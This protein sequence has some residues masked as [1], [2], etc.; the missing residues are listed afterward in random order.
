MTATDELRRLLAERGVEYVDDEGYGE[1]YPPERRITWSC[2]IAGE[3]MTVTARDYCIGI[4]DDGSSVYY[5]DLDFHEVFTPEQAVE[6]TLGRG[7]C[8]KLPSENNLTCIVRHEPTGMT[9]EYGYWR[10]SN[11]GCNCFDGA[12]YCMS[13]GAKVVGS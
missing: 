5:L 4:N 12:R 13:C 3:D 7:E 10:C 8:H 1:K 9:M 11:C 2:D 6:A